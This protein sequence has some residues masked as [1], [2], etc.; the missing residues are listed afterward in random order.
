MHES[1]RTPGPRPLAPGP[2]RETHLTKNPLKM[3]LPI[4]P[5]LR[6]QL[7]NRHLNIPQLQPHMPGQMR[8]P[9]APFPT[10][11]PLSPNSAT[12]IFKGV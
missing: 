9:A 5:R 10:S 4:S 7:K 12:I 1:L 3:R 6:N 11:G 2:R 8:H